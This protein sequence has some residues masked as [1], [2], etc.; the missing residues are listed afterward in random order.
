MSENYAERAQRLKTK[1]RKLLEDLPPYIKPMP[2]VRTAVNAI[3][4][5][6]NLVDDLLQKIKELENGED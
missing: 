5:A 2:Q 6:E 1:A 3:I 4:E